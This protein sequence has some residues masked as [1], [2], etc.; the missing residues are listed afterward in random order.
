M[1]LTFPATSSHADGPKTVSMA[2][3]ESSWRQT[4]SEPLPLTAYL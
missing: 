3:A 1:L 4:T 2:C